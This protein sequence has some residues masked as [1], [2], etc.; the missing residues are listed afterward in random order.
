LRN[1]TIQMVPPSGTAAVNQLQCIRIT[2]LRFLRQKHT[3]DTAGLCCH[4]TDTPGITNDR[5]HP[6]GD[7]VVRKLEIWRGPNCFD[8]T[9]DDGDDPAEIAD[10]ILAGGTVVRRSFPEERI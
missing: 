4:G 9:V 6:I 8:L 3:G 1:D 5:I 7:N 10:K 2:E